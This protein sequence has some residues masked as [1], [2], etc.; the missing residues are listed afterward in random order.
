MGEVREVKRRGESGTQEISPTVRNTISRLIY[1]SVF[2]DKA[3]L[4]YRTGKA[5]FF[6]DFKNDLNSCIKQLY[7]ISVCNDVK[8][9]MKK[10]S[11]EI[12]N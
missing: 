4:L 11:K 3:I 5:V 8:L 6:Y 1:S 2:C 7:Y 9:A 10:N 12:I